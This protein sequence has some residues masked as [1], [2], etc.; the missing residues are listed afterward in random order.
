MNRD[1]MIA[2]DEMFEII[3]RIREDHSPVIEKWKE[4][5]MTDRVFRKD[6][7]LYFCIKVEDPEFEIIPWE[8]EDK[9]QSS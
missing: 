1:F 3:R 8:D 9:D 5:T 7:Y 2:G 4:H 6:G